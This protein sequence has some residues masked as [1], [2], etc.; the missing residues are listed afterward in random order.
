MKLF[1]ILAVL[2]VLLSV[3]RLDAQQTAADEYALQ[4]RVDG[5]Y[6]HVDAFTNPRFEGRRTGTKGGLLAAEY[7]EN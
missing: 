5:L 1:P 2:A 3:V 7:I 4:I 6:D